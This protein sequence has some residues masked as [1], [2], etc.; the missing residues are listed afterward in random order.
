MTRHL[1]ADCHPKVCSTTICRRTKRGSHRP[2]FIAVTEA[3]LWRNTTA[4]GHAALR[5]SI[6]KHGRNDP[7]APGGFARQRLMR[8]IQIHPSISVS[9]SAHLRADRPSPPEK[10]TFRIDALLSHSIRTGAPGLSTCQRAMS[11]E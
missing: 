4:G 7:G 1:S 3:R 10:A 5:F 11:D 8:I 2:G 6:Y 9:R